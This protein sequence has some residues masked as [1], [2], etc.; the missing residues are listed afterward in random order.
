MSIGRGM[1]KKVVVQIYNE[2]LFCYRRNAFESALMRWINLEPI[3]QR[4]VSWKEKDI[5]CLLTHIYEIWKDGTDGP[6]Y[7]AAKETQ[8]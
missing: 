7:R 4:E 2:I 3:T 8:T 6:M 1:D 5:Y